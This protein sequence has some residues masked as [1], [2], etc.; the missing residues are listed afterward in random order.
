MKDNS[1]SLF[2]NDKREK[3]THPQ[4]K[5]SAMIDGRE[6]WI[7]AWTKTSAS[8]KRWQSLSFQ[9]KDNQPTTESGGGWQAPADDLDDEIPF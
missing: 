5:G 9:L 8:G 6:Y 1:G 7:S 3:D 4:A 2:V